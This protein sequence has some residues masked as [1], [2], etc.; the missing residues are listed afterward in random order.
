ML[1]KP[2]SARRRAAA[3]IAALLLILGAL[4]ATAAADGGRHIVEQRCLSTYGFCWSTVVE[5]G[6]VYLVMQSPEHGGEYQVCVQAPSGERA[7][8]PIR[9]RH[10]PP[11]PHGYIGFASRVSFERSFSFGEKGIYR[12]TWR[13][14][15]AGLRFSPAL[16]F[17]SSDL[18]VRNGPID[19]LS[20]FVDLAQVR[21]GAVDQPA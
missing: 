17:S 14:Y 8:R 10:R 5:G 2:Q 1:P 6:D 15:P 4:T 7:C 16:T 3:V 18:A 11:G 12:V 13:S 9:L 21:G 19:A 20:E